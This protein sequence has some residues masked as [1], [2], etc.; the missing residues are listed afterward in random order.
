MKELGVTSQSASRP[1]HMVTQ[2]WIVGHPQSLS[3]RL[4]RT[5]LAIPFLVL[6]KPCEKFPELSSTIPFR[7]WARGHFCPWSFLGLGTMAISWWLVLL[8]ILISLTIS[9]SF[10][11]KFMPVS[12]IC[13]VLYE[14][15]GREFI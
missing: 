9:S 6:Q 5:A 8:L 12:G 4:R 3:S 11:W 15:S 14:H 10:F 7:P 13:P 2:E 1:H